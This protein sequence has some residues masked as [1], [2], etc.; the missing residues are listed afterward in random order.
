MFRWW[1]KA[2]NRSCFLSLAA[3]RTPS[4]PWD[5]RFP[6]CVGCMCGGTMFSFVC[7][8]PSPTSAESC[9]SWFGWF[10]GTAAQSDFSTTYTSAVRLR[11]FADRPWSSDQGVLEISRFSCMLFLSV[12]GFSDYAGPT[13]HS[14]FTWLPCCLPPTRNEVGILISGLFAAQWPRPPMPLSPLQDT[15]RD[16]PCKT[17][18]QDG[19]AT[20]FPVGLLH[21]LQHAG[22]AQRTPLCPVA[23]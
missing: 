4:S 14:R 3:F 17:R 19:F 20:S 8:L 10:T 23:R 1:S 21:P 18:G 12:R 15:P 5:M 16:V 7:A 11:A 6:L 2:V 13:V 9:P 22:L